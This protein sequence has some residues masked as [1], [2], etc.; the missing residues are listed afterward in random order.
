MSG[1][2]LSEFNYYIE[3]Q[4]ELLTKH[5]GKVLLIKDHNVVGVY[6]SEIDAFEDAQKRYEAGTYLIQRCEPGPDSYTATF[7]SRVIFA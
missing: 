5:I 7:H 6:D 4:D 1:D 3:H 2:L